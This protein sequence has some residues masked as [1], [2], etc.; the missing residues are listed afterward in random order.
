M[1]RNFLLAS[2]L[3]I[4]AMFTGCS[5][6]EEI[7]STKPSKTYEA[8]VLASKNDIAEILLGAGGKGGIFEI[9][10]RT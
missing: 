7:I 1:K 8:T 2:L 9:L 3:A 6:D 4:A 5:Q 10:T